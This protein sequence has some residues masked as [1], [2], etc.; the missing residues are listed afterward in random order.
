M[1]PRK[2]HLKFDERLRK[3]D[4]I[5]EDTDGNSVHARLDKNSRHMGDM[6]RELDYFHSAEGIRD[7][8]DNIV[9]SIG[10]IYPETATDYVRIAYG[11]LCLDYMAS[12]VKRQ[13]DCSYSDLDWRRV[14]RRTWTYFKRKGFNNTRYKASFG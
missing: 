12:K 4:V 10:T 13:L 3:N 14:Y 8:I 2:Y 6:H 9:F 7:F 11:H 1:P 5:C